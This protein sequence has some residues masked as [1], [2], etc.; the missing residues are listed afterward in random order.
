[1]SSWSYR[2]TSLDTL[3]IVTL[4]TD[5]FKMPARRGGNVL[6]PFHDGRVFV[7]K[8]FEQ[9]SMALGLE[10]SANSLSELEAGIDAV[11][12]LF[13]RRSLGTLTQTLEDLTTRSI[14]AEYTGD[15]DPRRS[16]PLSVRMLL[17]FVCPDPFF[18]SS[19]LTTDTTTINASP[20]TYTVNNPGTAD[21]RNPRIVLAGPLSSPEITNTTNG[22]SLQYTGS[23]SAGHS[24]TIDVDVDTGEFTAVTDLAVNVIGNVTH[25][26]D[27]AFFVLDAG[28]NAL[29]VTDGTHTTGTVTIEFYPPYL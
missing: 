29:S 4:V 27:A 8:R 28:N 12:M 3:G 19:V 16:S 14:Q 10:V 25:D 21:E 5:S 2:G 20:K 23:I 26:G 15:L 18:R 1:M 17:E 6:I 9:R 7:E 22:V 11:K 24:V 13:G